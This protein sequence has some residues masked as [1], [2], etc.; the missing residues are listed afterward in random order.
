MRVVIG[1]PATEEANEYFNGYI[2]QVDGDDLLKS[3]EKI[4]NATWKALSDLRV[5]PD[6]RYADGK[7][8]IKEVVQHLIDTE[9]V[10]CYR[11][12][13]F[14][15][16]DL[17]D[18]L[19]FE[20]NYYA[21]ES[22]ADKREFHDIMREFDSVRIA[23]RA[24]FQSFDEETLLNEGRANGSKTSVRA[25]GWMLA[26]HEQHHLAVIKERYLNEEA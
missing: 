13:A 17:Q 18:L 9:R 16:K 4:H 25:L 23:T 14:A 6:H 20:E 10:F 2:E 8:S 15:R 7:W 22:K 3:M 26:G 19:G 24:L 12:L 21:R 5:S 1:R 11:A